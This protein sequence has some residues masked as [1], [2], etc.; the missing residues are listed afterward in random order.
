[1]AL[2][3]GRRRN[4]AN[5]LYGSIL[6]YRLAALLLFV[7]TSAFAQDRPTTGLAYNAKEMSSLQYRCSLEGADILKCD[8]V[9]SA[10][11]KKTSGRSLREVVASALAGL[12]NERPP[13]PE[14]CSGSGELAKMI[15]NPT[16]APER[17]QAMSAT[18]KKDLLTLDENLAAFCQDQ[19]AETVRKMVTAGYE[20]DSRSCRVSSNDFSM[21]FRR[22][23]R[24]NTWTSNDGPNGPCGTITVASMEQDPQ[25]PM[26]WNYVQKRVVTNPS[27]NWIGNAQCSAMDQSETRYNWQSQEAYVHC[28]YIEFG[29]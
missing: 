29:P 15:R 6:I 23:Q 16:T 17:I 21:R 18:E 26:F 20:R 14:N 2:A 11:R 4:P 28:D 19:S 9:Q 22:V 13:S 25:E 12:K 5:H 7:A 3:G 24:S 1:M 8:M 10:V 27:A